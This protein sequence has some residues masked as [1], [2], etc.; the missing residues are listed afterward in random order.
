[1]PHPLRLRVPSPAGP[2]LTGHLPFADAPG[3]PDPIEVT[4]RL[5]T[6]GGRPWFPVS[7]EFHYSRYPAAEWEEE[8][9]KMKAATVRSGIPLYSQR[10]RGEAL[11][12]R[13]ARH[14]T[15][16]AAIPVPRYVTVMRSSVSSVYVANLLQ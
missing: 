5:L 6:R 9:L 15:S 3:V 7:G 8:L 2:P 12:T 11:Y 4:S 16:I 14:G 1:M 13:L 10:A